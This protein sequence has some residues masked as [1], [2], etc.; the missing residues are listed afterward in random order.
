MMMKKKVLVVMA[1]M[2]AFGG[3]TGAVYA[4]QDD[5]KASVSTEA[6]ASTEVNVTLA[7]EADATVTSSTY[8]EKGKGKQGY[9]GLLNAI[10]NVKDK[11]AG[12]VIANLLLSNYEAKLTAEQ[13]AQLEAIVAKDEALTVAADL[14]DQQGSVT[15]AVYVQ[16]EAIKANVKNMNSYKKLG[17]LYDKI[18]KTGVK[19]YV[20][21]DEPAFEVAPFIR[22]GSTLVPFR[23]I[24]EALKAEVSWNADERSVTVSRDGITVKLF[25]GSTAATVNGEEV[26]LEVAAEIQ[27]GSTVVP[28]R[29]ISESLNADVQWEGETQSVVI[30]E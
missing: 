12:S 24:A 8:E 9:R 13:K 28:V 11:P 6:Q 17:K 26:T 1:A 5:K 10:E 16:K 30:N 27:A 20:N 22:D 19:L 25:I 15:E 21:G 29:F 18:G 2:L 3:S 7:A 14:L 23:A 4:K